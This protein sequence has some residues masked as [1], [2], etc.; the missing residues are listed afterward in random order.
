MEKHTDVAH[1]EPNFIEKPDE[2]EKVYYREFMPGEVIVSM[3]YAMEPGKIK[4]MFPDIQIDEIIGGYSDDPS[5]LGTVFLLRLTIKTKESVLE[6]ISIIDK[7][8]DVAYA[9]PN[10]IERPDEPEKVYDKEFIPGEVIVGT[11]HA[12]EPNAL[13]S[14]FPELQIVEVIGGYADTES[15]LRTVFLVKLSVKTKGIVFEAIDAIMKHPD[16]N[17][18]VPNFIETPDEN[19]TSGAK[20]FV[21]GEAIVGTKYAMEPN[22]IKAMFPELQIVEVIGGYGDN[23]ST[24]RTVFLVKLSTKTKDSVLNAISVFIEHPDVA[25][26]EPNY[27]ERPDDPGSVMTGSSVVKIAAGYYKHS[28]ALKSDG[29][30]WAWGSN[31]YGELGDGTS[32]NRYLPQQ[33]LPLHN[34]VDIAIGQLYSMALENDGTVWAWGWNEYGQLGDGTSILKRVPVKV[35]GINSVIAISAGNRHS[36]ALKSDGTVWAWGDN[37]NGQLGDGTNTSRISPTQVHGLSNVTAIAT[38]SHFSVALKSDGTVWSWGQNDHG[39]LGDSTTLMRVSPVQILGI[40][41]ISAV[42]NGA[43]NGYAIKDDGTAYVWGSNSYNTI[44]D[45]TSTDRTSPIQIA[46]INGMDDIGGG[47]DHS[48]SLKNNGT[49]WTWGRNDYGQLGNGTKVKSTA[50]QQSPIPNGIIAISGGW[51]YSLALDNDG[52]VWAWGR[53]DYGQLGDG[54]TKDRLTPVSISFGNTAPTPTSTPTATPAP[55]TTTPT[56]TP[57]PTAL[58]KPTSA[59][60]PTL[61]P[62]PTATPTLM[63]KATPT[64][65]PTPSHTP[66]VTPIPTPA[67]SITPTPTPITATPTQTPVPPTPTPMAQPTPDTDPMP[68]PSPEPDPIPIQ[69]PSPGISAD[70]GS[71]ASGAGPSSSASSASSGFGSNPNNSIVATPTPS[72][73][74][75]QSPSHSAA[76]S[77]EAVQGSAGDEADGDTRLPLGYMET[78]VPVL[79]KGNTEVYMV[80]YPDGTVRPNADITRAETALLVYTL[81]MNEDKATYIEYASQF[82]DVSPGRWYAKAVAYLTAAKIIKGFPDGTFGGGKAITRAEFA[83]VLSRFW[84]ASPDGDMPFKD[85]G[86]HWARND[87]LNAYNNKWVNGYTDSTFKPD[88]NVTRAEAIAMLNRV[89]ARDISKYEGYPMKFSDVPS[90]KWYYMD[91]VAAS[92]DLR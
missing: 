30:V 48:I 42:Y 40:S 16:I 19:E 61:S 56:Q 86:S 72:P 68:E 10:F 64:Q 67:N 50:P 38:G 49:V 71:G 21:P 66:T 14:M 2:P 22:A 90:G 58:P 8:T 78:P 84:P 25:Y 20:E 45:G 70:S 13:K 41:N 80:G 26:A 91:I 73:S 11:K 85:V 3:K 29:T 17:Y 92:N 6:A 87:I 7:H 12:M 52:T 18:A 76:L 5:S 79:S 63:P 69:T 4:T 46:S 1:A 65:T 24:L 59:P 31:I 54:T 51:S 37:S 35:H 74:P 39:Q 43:N 9:E 28:L 83:A 77:S 27:I 75:I 60:T 89:I 44:G 23:T 62:T 57:T 55:I 34:I 88:S 15:S 81:I 33:V 36:L 82:S 32:I 47:L 53:N